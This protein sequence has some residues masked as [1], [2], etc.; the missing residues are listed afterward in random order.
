MKKR[1]VHTDFIK[2]ILEKY[3]SPQAQGQDEI[4]FP[5]DEVEDESKFKSKKNKI[6]KLN[7][8]GD[9]EEIEE[10]DD[11]TDDEIIDELLNE[12]KRLKKKHESYNIRYR[13]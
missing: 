4:E 2:F 9:E 12:Y 7:E 6:K 13:R 10:D 11:S 3:S 5:D 1:H 8:L